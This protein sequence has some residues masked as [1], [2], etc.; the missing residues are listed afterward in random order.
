MNVEA[1]DRFRD[2]ISDAGLFLDFDGTL[3]EIVDR[4]QDAR[5][6]E[7]VK[8]S[9]ISLSNR[10]RLVAIVSGR[11]AHQLVEWLGGDVE[12]WGVHG[13]EVGRAGIVSVSEEMEP[14]MSAVDSAKAEL[15]RRLDE[16]DHPGVLFE[17]KGV[18]ANVHYRMSPD[19][20]GAR[21]VLEP[22]V[23][24]I[25]EAH[26][27]EVGRGRMTLE[28][29]PRAGVSKERVVRERVKAE[30]LRAA[31][32]IG[33]DTVDLPAFDALD[34]LA[35]DDFATLRV[36]VRSEEADPELIRRAD[37]VVDGPSGVLRFLRELSS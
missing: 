1:V 8:E 13:A 10:C 30:R 22:V 34:D 17:D 25:A 29:K 19:P 11:S 27:L 16:L 21:R 31:A 20:D 23:E 2:R 6:L 3:S 24:K 12:I 5:P 26:D 9:L 35:T 32:F 14:F 4:P 37:L 18:V 15:R 33:D 7:G 28:L 36:A